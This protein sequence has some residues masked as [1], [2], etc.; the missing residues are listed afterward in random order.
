MKSRLLW[1]ISLGLV[2]GVGALL[3]FGVRPWSIAFALL[4]LVCPAV[5][6]WGASYAGRSPYDIRTDEGWPAYVR[7][8]LRGAKQ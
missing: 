4:M 6:V 1:C 7:R 8:R 2:T 3:W 5:I